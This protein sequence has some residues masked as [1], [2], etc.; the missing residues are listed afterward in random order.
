VRVQSSPFVRKPA[1]SAPNKGGGGND[2]YQAATRQLPCSYHPTPHTANNTNDPS[3]GDTAQYARAVESAL[4][5]VRRVRVAEEAVMA[6]NVAAFERE[7][8]G[9]MGS[10][11]ATYRA[12]AA[13]LE[14]SMRE[15]VER[16]RALVEEAVSRKVGWG[17]GGRTNTL[18]H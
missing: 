6:S 10:I 9:G 5:E 2:S 13:S 8:I 3:G 18:W 15:Y 1:Y 17:A 4:S 12:T 14:A 16:Q 7:L 11:E